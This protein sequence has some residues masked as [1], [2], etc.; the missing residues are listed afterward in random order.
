MDKNPRTK[1]LLEDFP[2]YLN[3]FS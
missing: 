1:Q 2:D 3:F